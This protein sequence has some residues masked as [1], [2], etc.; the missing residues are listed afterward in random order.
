MF[1]DISPSLNLVT[2]QSESLTPTFS[3]IL[4][5]SSGFALPV[6]ILISLPLVFII[7]LP[8]NLYIIFIRHLV[9]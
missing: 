7:I 1:T 2:T 4:A 9:Y 6:I 8:K 3:A 5:A